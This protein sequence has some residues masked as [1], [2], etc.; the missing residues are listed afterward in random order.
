[1]TVATFA[2]A[3]LLRV[4]PRTQI[5]R[6]VGR[7]CDASLH[8][9]VS[10]AAVSIYARAYRVDLNDAITPDRGV[11]PSFD[12]FF[13]RTLRDGLRPMCSDESAIVSPADGRIEDI[14]PV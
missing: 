2:A 3:Q 11:Y 10:A 7:L 4:L 5:T 1:M 9:L 8:P 6:A 13:T 14:G 12:A